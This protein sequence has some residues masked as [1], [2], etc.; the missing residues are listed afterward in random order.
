MTVNLSFLCPELVG[1]LRDGAYE[2]SDGL[3]AQQAM[4]EPERKCDTGLNPDFFPWT[5]PIIN[6]AVADWET[7]LSPDDRM[8]IHYIV[9]GG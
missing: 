3:T 9:M 8:Q 4:L 6:G 2:I 7:I 5:F 1:T